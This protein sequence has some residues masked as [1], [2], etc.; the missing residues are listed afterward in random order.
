MIHSKTSYDSDT[1]E[2]RGKEKEKWMGSGLKVI[3]IKLFIKN[4]N[5]KANKSNLW[6]VE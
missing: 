5:P 6:F 2:K 4:K 1:L 3:L